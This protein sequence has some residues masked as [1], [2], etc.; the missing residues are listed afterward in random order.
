[1]AK[2]AAFI[3]LNG[4]YV[5][6]LQNFANGNKTLQASY[7]FHFDQTT[8]VTGRTQPHSRNCA[9]HTAAVTTKLF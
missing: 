3:V 8:I 1:M 9:Y 2:H 7:A 4:D 5:G 6:F